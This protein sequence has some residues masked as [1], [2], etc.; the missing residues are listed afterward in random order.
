MEIFSVNTVAPGKNDPPLP[1]YVSVCIYHSLDHCKDN[2]GRIDLSLNLMNE[3]EIDV[4][5][6]DLIHNLEKTRKKAKKEL[7]KA[8]ERLQNQLLARSRN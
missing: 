1:P 6:D 8:K 2:E 4:A 3:M 7:K 5:I